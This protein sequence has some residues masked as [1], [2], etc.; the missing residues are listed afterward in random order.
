MHA[1][2]RDSQACTW[3]W[4]QYRFL[5]TSGSLK[6]GIEKYVYIYI[7]I[8]R[9]NGR[10]LKGAWNVW[11]FRLLP[12][13][14]HKRSIKEVSFNIIYPDVYAGECFRNMQFFFNK[15]WYILIKFSRLTERS[16]S[17]INNV[18]YIQD[19]HL[20]SYFKK[21]NTKSLKF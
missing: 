6:Y 17:F 3:G 2:K 18:F 15:F 16:N 8:Y 1:Y 5:Q 12:Y 13:L 14:T 7:Y 9:I 19:S 11:W 10:A 20:K 21:I 4:G